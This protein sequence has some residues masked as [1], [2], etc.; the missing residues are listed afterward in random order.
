MTNLGGKYIT[1]TSALFVLLE[2]NT[3]SYIYIEQYNSNGKLTMSFELNL[4]QSVYPLMNN[5]S[6]KST[7]VWNQMR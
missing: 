1:S 7:T 2:N 4:P 6:P 5:L 3:E